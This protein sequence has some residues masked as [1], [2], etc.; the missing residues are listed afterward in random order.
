MGENDRDLPMPS[1]AASRGQKTIAPQQGRLNWEAACEHVPIQFGKE[2]LRI[3]C[4]L[5]LFRKR[6]RFF[7]CPWRFCRR[8]FRLRLDHKRGFRRRAHCNVDRVR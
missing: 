4:T 8:R 6:Q 5:P 3:C 7:R 2:S 1:G